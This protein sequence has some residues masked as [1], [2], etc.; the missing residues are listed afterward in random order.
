[1]RLPDL[2][3]HQLGRWQPQCH[4]CGAP[5][6]DPDFESTDLFVMMSLANLDGRYARHYNVA[7]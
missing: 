6:W 7:A 5:A 4:L 1:V 2:R 3:E